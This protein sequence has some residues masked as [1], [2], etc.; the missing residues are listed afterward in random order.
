MDLNKDETLLILK[1]ID[2]YEGSEES[3]M[4]E[5]LQIR[6]LEDKLTEHFKYLQNSK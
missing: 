3:S 6:H 2:H 5:D 4:Q 1:A